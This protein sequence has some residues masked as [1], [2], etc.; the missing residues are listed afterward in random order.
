MYSALA[1]AC[2]Y[3]IGEGGGE[4]KGNHGVAEKDS[5]ETTQRGCAGR[6]EGG[7]VDG[8]KSKVQGNRRA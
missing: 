6:K 3:S 7:A 1:G 5:P 8:N 2:I 4:G